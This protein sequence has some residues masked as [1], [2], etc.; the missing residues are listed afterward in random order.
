MEMAAV[1]KDRPIAEAREQANEACD[2][3]LHPYAMG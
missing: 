3:I 1:A 2:F